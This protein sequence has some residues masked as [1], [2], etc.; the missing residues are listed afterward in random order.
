MGIG[1]IGLYTTTS[2]RGNTLA[3]TKQ[4]QETSRDCHSHFRGFAMTNC[5]NSILLGNIFLLLSLIVLIAVTLYPPIYSLFDD[6][7]IIISETFFVNNFIIFVIP[8]LGTIG[9]FTT[10][11]S[12][13]N[14]L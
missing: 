3:L 10:R 11:S 4:S 1:S 14:I 12:I 9:L 6:K 5:G 7:P 13:K 8:I 2:L